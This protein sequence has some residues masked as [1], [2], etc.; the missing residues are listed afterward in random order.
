VAS[1]WLSTEPIPCRALGRGGGGRGGGTDSVS[2]S[3]GREM[4]ISVREEGRVTAR[5]GKSEP[6]IV[7]SPV[8]EKEWLILNPCRT[9]VA[10]GYSK[11]LI[12]LII[13]KRK[14]TVD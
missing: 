3:T 7:Y 8:L 9:Y 10:C 13:L 1:Q 11:V 12:N 2:H 5:A 6:S 4:G 14:E